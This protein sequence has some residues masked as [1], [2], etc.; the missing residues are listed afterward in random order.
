MSD[1]SPTSDTAKDPAE[2]YAL[3]RERFAPMVRFGGPLYA[4]IYTTEGI[5]GS[6]YVG[7]Q[8]KWLW[9]PETAQVALARK[10]HSYLS[11]K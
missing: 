5:S 3:V 2:I 9:V 4:G 8:N 6:L 7:E 10:T 1:I 11:S